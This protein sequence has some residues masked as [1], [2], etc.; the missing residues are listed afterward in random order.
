MNCDLHIHS[1]YSTGNQSLEEIIAEALSKDIQ[2]ISITDDDSME[3]YNELPD[4][5]SKMG[6]SYIKGLQVSANKKGQL[7]RLMAYGC[8]SEHEELDNLL[9]GNRE[10]WDGYGEKLI[11]YMSEYYHQLSVDGYRRHKKDPRYGGFKYN[12]YLNSEGMDGSDSGVKP[13]FMEHMDDLKKMFL[14]MP[15]SPVED[16]IEIIHDAG[17]RA[18]VPGGYLR[19]VNTFAA[20]IDSLKNLGIDGLE[21]FSAS[22]DKKMS[23]AAK[24]FALKH[25]LLMTGGGDGHGSWASQDRYAI[26]ITD[27]ELSELQLGDIKI[28]PED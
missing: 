25:K 24:E 1:N 7:F 18:I 26:G 22:Y 11:T 21:I 9:A 6:I 23:N 4:L 20:D 28:Y 2:L 5:A 13:F 19:D 15:F 14:E 27:I 16:V 10:V 3:A 12:S 8:I 17:G